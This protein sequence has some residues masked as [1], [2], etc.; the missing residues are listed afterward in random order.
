MKFDNNTCVVEKQG[1]KR[2]RQ[3]G[4][5]AGRK[6][7]NML[8]DRL[9]SNKIRA[10]IRELYSNA[11]DSHRAA[12][13]M[14]IQPTMH[15]PTIF[16][17]EFILRDFGTGISPTDIKDIYT[18]VLESTKTD[19]DDDIGGFGLGSKTPFCYSENFTVR[20]FFNGMVY[21]YAMYVNTDGEP[22]YS[23]VGKEE[24]TEPNGLEI[25][26]AVKKEDINSFRSEASVALL[27]FTLQPNMT[28]QNVIYRNIDKKVV[29]NGWYLENASNYERKHP[30]VLVGPV[31][32][33]LDIS[34]FR[35]QLTPT[36][37]R[38]AEINVTIQTEIKDVEVAPSREALSY[39]LKTIEC[40]KNKIKDCVAEFT[41]Y[42]NKKDRK[43]TR[44]NSSH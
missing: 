43:S 35:N 21:A 36:E 10:I 30:T 17:P 19:S 31:A 34:S 26:F 11:Y 4:V 15:L 27:H 44:L 16:A 41:D 25:K 28:G 40:L 5:A 33:P 29:G 37:Q 20:S 8:F 42:A 32:Y 13:T 23:M 1:I 9:Y 7:F 24:T 38:F 12:N 39:S 3:F 14:N 22:T 2:E 6:L 18:V